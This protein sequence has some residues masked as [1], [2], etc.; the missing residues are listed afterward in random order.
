[1]QKLIWHNEKRKL[2][3]L[4]PYGE[5]PRQLTKKQ[6]QDLTKSLKKFNLVEIPAINTD[7]KIC[8]GHQRIAILKEQGNDIEI[9]VRVPNR[10]LTD[11]EFQ[12]YNIRSNK[13]LGEFDFDLLA[14]NFD[15]PDL[16]EFGFE[17]YELGIGVIESDGEIDVNEFSSKIELKL[18]FNIN[19]FNKVNKALDNGE[20]SKEDYLMELL[21]LDSA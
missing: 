14:N 9:D 20:G 16:L 8:A 10:K 7:N 12:E 21:G 11:K 5:N 19:D 4:I 2:S 15:L 3:D 13:N 17:E 6:H 18:Y 1:M